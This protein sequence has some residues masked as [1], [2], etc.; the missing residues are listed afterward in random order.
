MTEKTEIDRIATQF[1]ANVPEIQTYSRHELYCSGASLILGK[2]R[3][4]VNNHALEEPKSAYEKGLHDGII[5]TWEK[6]AELFVHD[7]DDLDRLLGR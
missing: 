4:L 7:G 3:D 1:L 5:G 6:I 2:L